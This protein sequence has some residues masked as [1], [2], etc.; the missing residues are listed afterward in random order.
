MYIQ[1]D[2]RKSSDKGATWTRPYTA[3]I[4]RAIDVAITTKGTLVFALK[5]YTQATTK[6]TVFV[7]KTGAEPVSKVL[8]FATGLD[9][10]EGYDRIELAVSDNHPD[11]MYALCSYDHS[12]EEKWFNL[13]RSTDG[14]DSWS[15]V[16]NQYTSSVSP[17]GDN[18]QGYYDNVIA[19][20]P[21]DPNKVVF[22]GIDLWEWTPGNAFEQVS[23]WIE[24]AWF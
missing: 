14:G 15:S 21:N 24:E 13:F 6:T 20:Y 1:V 10:G 12:V 4:G 11:Y 8:D 18:K 23:F 2:K 19:M 17:F 16:L 3:G 22:G 5:S 9:A 7:S